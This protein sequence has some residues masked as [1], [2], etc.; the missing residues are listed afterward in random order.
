MAQ[1]PR[2][3]I[4]YELEG[5]PCSHEVDAPRGNLTPDQARF[6]LESLHSDSN[7]ADITELRI[8]PL[9]PC[10]GEAGPGDGWQAGALDGV[11]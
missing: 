4:H 9:T 5:Q 11:A 6:Q 2:F 3:R 8:V 7:P 10:E 1:P